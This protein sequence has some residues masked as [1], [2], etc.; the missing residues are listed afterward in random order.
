MIMNN[1]Y[2]ST[3]ELASCTDGRKASDGLDRLFGLLHGHGVF[4]FVL[5]AIRIAVPISP[6]PLCQSIFRQPSCLLSIVV[7]DS[8]FRKTSIMHTLAMFVVQVLES[9]ILLGLGLG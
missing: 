2:D 8:S 1:D 6:S 5:F 7:V 9:S 3:G 4:V